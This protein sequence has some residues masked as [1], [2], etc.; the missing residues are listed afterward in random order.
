MKNQKI[1]K[2]FGGLKNRFIDGKPFAEL[3]D[4]I[5]KDLDRI[6][7]CIMTDMSENILEATQGILEEARHMSKTLDEMKDLLATAFTNETIASISELEL[8]VWWYKNFKA[9]PIVTWKAFALGLETYLTKYLD[10]SLRE[11]R[12][13][14]PHLKEFFDL[15]S[16]DSVDV[17]ELRI[18][19]GDD[20]L[21]N[22]QKIKFRVF[23]LE[24]IAVLKNSV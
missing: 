20:P 16:D 15:D 2:F 5:D 8:K 24:K 13:M 17:N 22:K 4:Q 21:A 14:M 3:I 18:V 9:E 19:L 10:C 6:C 12:Q 7:Q 11:A 23:L 1:K